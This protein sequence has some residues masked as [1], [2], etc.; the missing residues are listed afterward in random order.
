MIDQLSFLAGVF[1]TTAGT[2]VGQLLGRRL[3]RPPRPP[4]PQVCGCGHH[5]ATHDLESGTCREDVRRE[6]YKQNGERN[7]YEWVECACVR[8]TGEVPPDLSQFDLPGWRPTD[9]PEEEG[10]LTP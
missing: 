7:G 3:R 2:A 10:R 1:A 5:L 8:Y 9:R 4:D 6:H